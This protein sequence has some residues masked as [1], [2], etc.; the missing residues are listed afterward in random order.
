MIR[1]AAVYVRQFWRDFGPSVLAA[2]QVAKMVVHAASSPKP[3]VRVRGIQRRPD[4]DF[5]MRV[6]F[7]LVGPNT[8]PPDMR[9]AAVCHLYYPDLA[10]EFLEA[11]A[12]IPGRLDVVLSTDTEAKRAKISRTFAAWDKGTVEVRIVANRGRDI[13]PKL[14]AYG[15]VHAK[16]HLV[17]YMHSKRTVRTMDNGAIVD[18][19][20][21]WRRHLLHNLVGST[22]IAASILEAFRRDP[23]LGLIMAQHWEPV[24]RYVDWQEIYFDARDLARRMGIRLTPAHIIDFPSGSMFWARP[25]ALR[26]MLDLGLHVEDFPPEAGQ[27]EGTLAHIIERLFLFTVEAAGYR[28]AKVCDVA[29]T[30]YPETVIPIET[31]EALDAYRH[32]YGF[33]LTAA[34]PA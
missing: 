34:G 11:F 5:S 19:G 3:G 2:R 16:Y 33:R 28:W 25:A 7:G 30:G 27:V 29:Q 13:A 31:P 24:R 26:P 9:V 21:D 22:E 15:D 8:P 4:H 14:T 32:R 20:A 23:R 12:R 17:L 18:V 10:T 1:D 6:P